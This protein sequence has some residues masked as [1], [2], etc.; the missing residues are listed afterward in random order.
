VNAI[1]CSECFH[2][3]GLRLDAQRLGVDDLAACPNCG[4]TGG[5]KLNSVR[6]ATLTH[7]FFVWGS[8]LRCEYG[9]AP[10]IQFNQRQNTSIT[11]PS[12]LEADIGL[13]ERAL[14][15]DFFHYGRRLCMIREVEPLKAL[16]DGI[17][18][19]IVIERILR[20]YPARPLH[21]EE[22]FYRIRKAPCSPD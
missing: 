13:I 3:Q 10:Q 6:L 4:A 17:A 21:P 15:V 18:S 20:D 2:D 22:T 19:P 9:A 16:Q 12:W 7:Q 11:M 14:C 1:A 8:Q 5:R